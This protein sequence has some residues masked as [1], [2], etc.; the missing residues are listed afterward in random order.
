MNSLC[1]SLA[2]CLSPRWLSPTWHPTTNIFPT[3]SCLLFN[4]HKIS[5]L[6]I[7]KINDP[8]FHI[9]NVFKKS[10]SLWI[11]AI[12][13]TKS[14]TIVLKRLASFDNIP[15]H[16]ISYASCMIRSSFFFFEKQF[17]FVGQMWENSVCQ[18]QGQSV[19]IEKASTLVGRSLNK[20]CHNLELTTQ[21]WSARQLSDSI[22]QNT[23]NYNL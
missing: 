1:P 7:N 22:S 20:A 6:K 18:K 14:A 19:V 16:N 21:S 10:T 15:I 5:C 3:C 8:L 4:I 2:A 9:I 23:Q 17:C 12:S 11:T 13:L